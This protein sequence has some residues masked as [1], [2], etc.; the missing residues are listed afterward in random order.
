[1]ESAKKISCLFCCLYLG[2]LLKP[3][4]WHTDFI[5]KI[6]ILLSCYFFFKSIFHSPTVERSFNFGYANLSLNSLSGSLSSIQRLN[7][8]ESTDKPTSEARRS[9][10]FKNMPKRI[11]LSIWNCVR[12]KSCYLGGTRHGVFLFSCKNI[13]FP[14]GNFLYGTRQRLHR[15]VCG[16]VMLFELCDSGVILPG[17]EK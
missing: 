4:S 9:S 3:V 12:K 15:P 17:K 5:K 2:F 11:L 14:A 16:K 6:T 10:S 1:M 7:S 8:E 13:F